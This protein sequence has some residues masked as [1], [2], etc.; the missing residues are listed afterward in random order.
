M[1]KASAP[2]AKGRKPSKFSIAE[3]LN[4]KE[5]AEE[6]VSAETKEEDLPTN[7]FTETDLRS[8][9]ALFLEEIRKNDILVYSAINGF[10]ISKIDEDTI[11]VNY[12]SD[13]AKAEFDKVQA[14]FFNHFK[15]KANHHRIKVE[16]KM[17][18]ALKV[19]II[20]KR[21][22]FEKMAEKNPVLRDLDDLFKFDFS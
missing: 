3:A 11:R 19:E 13:T 15:R 4:K 6:T 22:L 20:T 17:D 12:P 18:T 9:W 14:E 8:E 10:R 7:H 16:Y 2:I 21:G 5:E 1:Q